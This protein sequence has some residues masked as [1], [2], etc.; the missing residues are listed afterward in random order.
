MQSQDSSLLSPTRHSSP[1]LFCCRLPSVPP[2]SDT[3]DPFQ[4]KTP[5]ELHPS[6]RLPGPS[7][8]SSSR[9]IS[10]CP[11]RQQRQLK[12]PRCGNN[13]E[14]RS[15]PWRRSA[16]SLP[17]F[18]TWSASL[19]VSNEPRMAPGRGAEADTAILSQPLSDDDEGGG[20]GRYSLHEVLREDRKKSPLSNLGNTPPSNRKRPNGLMR[21]KTNT[22]GILGVRVTPGTTTAPLVLLLVEEK[23]PK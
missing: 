10:D 14:P 20:L 8:R 4:R 13:E 23:D 22:R 1:C 17:P 2:R 7:P 6:H 15:S 12:N 16:N 18:T 19:S 5:S 9:T 21:A 3:T 11:C